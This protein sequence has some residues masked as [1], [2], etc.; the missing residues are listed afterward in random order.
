MAK[1][2]EAITGSGN[3]LRK[4]QKV[5]VGSGSMAALLY[6]EFCMLFSYFP[7]A[8]GMIL[9]KLFWPRMFDRCGK[10]TVFGCGVVVRQPNRIRLGKSVVISEYCILDGRRSTD[11][12]ALEL[13][14][15][16]MLS[17]N[18]MLSSKE[19][20]IVIGDDVGINAQTIVQSTYGNRVSI[21]DDCV[22]G[23]R[24]FVIGGG[25]Y[26]TG[27][28]DQLIRKQPIRNDGGVMLGGNVWLGGNVSILGGVTIGENSI[29]AAGSVVT[30]SFPP[31]SVGMGVPARV[32]RNRN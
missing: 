2:H 24:C 23:Q 20:S 4:Y 16:V 10:G 29:V 27:Q 9:R 22:I 11:G 19:G 32:V 6:Y 5:V 14:D 1:T 21:G 17:N 31:G 13:G 26:D 12:M 7:G 8:L 18:V 28:L 15:N 25:N 3:P 30:K